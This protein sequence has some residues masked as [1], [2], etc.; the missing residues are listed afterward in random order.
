ML[1]LTRRQ[2]DILDFLI[3]KN[4][5]VTL[6]SLSQRFEVSKR[7]IQNDIC[8]IEDFLNEH[9]L[10]LD[11]K[12]S[13]GVRIVADVSD[14]DK[15]R[16]IVAN[17][18]TRVLDRQERIDYILIYLLCNNKTTYKDIAEKLKI[19]RQTVINSFESVR[20]SAVSSKLD[21]RT[22]KSV[23][24]IL[25]GEEID[26]RNS[27][28]H[29]AF[30]YDCESYVKD[31]V[32][33]KELLKRL[34]SEFNFDFSDFDKTLAI[35][36]F[37]LSRIN[38]GCYLN[39]D[40]DRAVFN[41]AYYDVVDDYVNND[42][43][44]IYLG[45]LILNERVNQI[46]NVIDGSY[47]DEAREI[48][49]YLIDSLMKYQPVKDME[50]LDVFTT[51]LMQH[52]HC[53]LY[54]IRNN[55]TVNNEL[56]EQVRYTMPVLYAFTT[57]KLKNIQKR[58]DVEFDDTEI[59][60]IT[61]YLA[62]IYEVNSCRENIRIL[63]VCNYGM[64]SSAILKSRIESRI[65]GIELYGPVNIDAAKIYVENGSVDLVV[66][67]V[68][69]D[70]LGV[71]SVVINPLLENKDILEI[72]NK[73]DEFFF[74]R[75]CCQLID[76]S[77]VETQEKHF[78]GDYLRR[79]DIQIISDE[80]K[81][82]EAIIKAANPLLNKG[83]INRHYID[84]MISAVD[85]YGTYMVL[86]E[87][88]AYVHAGKDDGIKE[89][90]TALLVSKEKIDFGGKSSKEIYNIFVLGIKDQSKT[91]IFNAV[92]ILNKDENIRKL[93]EKDINIEQILRMHD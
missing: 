80:I 66:S 77:D 76:A 33:A 8:Y 82:Q 16:G 23:G 34:E 22:E 48:T 45:N 37:C 65:S 50:K 40:N 19:S 59:S 55:L 38:N 78:L 32:Q 86:S 28:I 42:V 29:L 83:L 68:S 62:S 10:L 44:K 67:T 88:T 15:I 46:T 92:Y 90:C 39:V 21:V 13:C 74:E 52:I 24:I 87:N 71:P 27:F 91:D 47:D 63:L 36:S 70:N 17:C 57:R 93:R 49:Q 30:K 25:S 51:G 69:I 31:T 72:N 12:P 89:N 20:E 6:N 53:A 18:E 4:D 79:E 64:A 14:A 61:M 81:W 9:E 1:E 54:R 26:I 7:T 3:Q 43:E 60:F 11:K 41:D 5:Y 73:I 56:L 35:V 75:M 2:R 84:E 58:Y 85:K